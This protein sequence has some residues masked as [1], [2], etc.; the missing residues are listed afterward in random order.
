MAVD[1]VARGLALAPFNLLFSPAGN[2]IDQR[3]GAVAQSFR[4][5]NTYTDASNYEYGGISWNLTSNTCVIG[6]SHA[7]TGV[8]R[9][10]ELRTGGSSGIALNQ[11]GTQLL[12]ME[13]TGIWRPFA[14][15]TVDLGKTANRW[16]DFYISRDFYTAGGTQAVFRSAT[17]I[18]SG[19]AAAAGTLTN[20]PTAGNP[21]KWIPINDNGTTRY[22]P[23]W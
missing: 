9:T 14:D 7:G 2:V 5:Y 1:I 10:L 3:S 23:A 12:A 20:A 4:V 11:A 21:T 22:I 16:R 8:S 18:T 6:M 15:A 13:S 19:G 17:A